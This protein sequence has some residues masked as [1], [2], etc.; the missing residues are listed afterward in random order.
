MRFRRAFSR[1]NDLGEDH[2]PAPVE[3]EKLLTLWYKDYM[4]LPPENERIFYMGNVPAEVED[5]VFTKD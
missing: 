5:Y 2:F 3:K 4:T 1:K